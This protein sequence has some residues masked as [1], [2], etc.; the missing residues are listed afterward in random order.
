ME[1][2][3][4]DVLC[5]GS[6]A[7]GIR[8][9]IEAAQMGCQVLCIGSGA[10]G[11]GT[12]TVL[13]AGVLRGTSG[14]YDQEAH[15]RDT[16]IAGRGLN[17]L[18][19]V[20]VLVKEAPQRL[21]ELVRWGMPCEKRGPFLFAK[22]SA[23]VWG[24]AIVSCLLDKAGSLGV[25]FLGSTLVL[26]LSAEEGLMAAFGFR[27]PAGPSVEVRSKAVVLATGGAGAL[28]HR[29]DNPK[30]MLGSGYA[31]ALEI[32]AELQDMEF[33][34]FYPVG[35]AQ[36]GLPPLVIP[37]RLADMG[38][39]LNT[40]GEDL[41][42]KWG[43][44][45]RPAA[46]KARDRLSQAIFRE[47]EQGEV[48]WLDLRGIGEED[49]AR[50]P[51]SSSCAEFLKRRLG[52][53]EKPLKVAPMAHFMMGGVR[54]DPWCRTKVPGFFAAGE[55][56]GGLHGANRLGGNALTEAIVFGARAGKSAALW[57]TENRAKRHGG[58]LWN[59]MKVE[60]TPK[61]YNRHFL[62]RLRKSMWELGGVVRGRD[63]LLEAKRLLESRMKEAGFSEFGDPYS[64]LL[65]LA[66]KTA[67]IIL[68][69]SLRREETRG[70]HFRQ[71]FPRE[72]DREWRGHL[73]VESSPGEELKWN[74]EPVRGDCSQ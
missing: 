8:A 57:A 38:R 4:C 44:S 42:E 2:L 58:P 69:A 60:G 13:S 55:A 56:A 35:L 73:I 21:E 17:D 19:L 14:S 34:Q 12:S 10:P 50:D 3:E 62:E 24:K 71:D 64:R 40:K 32:G 52:G 33:V 31:L 39:L 63:G 68:E 11:Q 36:D 41:L 72:D 46:E 67:K 43:I 59:E 9:A 53:L 15:K 49:L 61:S 48:I 28:Y 5:I 45:E 20:E 6:G 66:A 1:I 26:G 30:G 70:A 27:R 37:P 16:L 25:R 54:I 74:F 47:I 7:S 29:H 23:P 65:H 22:G 51:V 18:G